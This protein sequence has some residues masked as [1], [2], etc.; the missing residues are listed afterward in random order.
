M[1]LPALSFHRAPTTEQ[2]RIPKSHHMAGCRGPL[3]TRARP[4]KHCTWAQTFPSLCSLQTSAR[5]RTGAE[6]PT[7]SHVD[8]DIS[9]DGSAV[10]VAMCVCDHRL[11]Q[12]AMTVRVRAE[13]EASIFRSCAQRPADNYN[14]VDEWQ[15]MSAVTASTCVVCDAINS[16]IDAESLS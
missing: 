10:P 5:N 11:L 8:R 4:C 15:L 13:E 16:L 3:L 6:I 12:R 7:Q 14:L 9:N 2:S 1:L